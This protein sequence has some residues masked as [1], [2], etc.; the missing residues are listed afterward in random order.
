MPQLFSYGTLRD[1]AVQQANF[2]RRLTGHDDLLPGYTVRM[3]EITDPDVLAVSGQS[4]HPIL[5][6]TG[7]PADVVPGEVFELTDDELLAAD[8]YEV[9]D[10]RRVLVTLVSGARAW[11]YAA[12]NP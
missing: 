8:S 1:P 6:E 12:T 4:H 7:D 11:V 10:Y 3:L 9:D 2:G 5:I